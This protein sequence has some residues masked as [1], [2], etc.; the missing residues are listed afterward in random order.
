MSGKKFGYPVFV[1]IGDTNMEGNVYWV[2]YFAWL[3]K[4][5]EVFL[6]SIFPDF[7]KILASGY[8]IV[9]HETNIK[10]IASAFFTEE[11]ILEISM[12]EVRST[13]AK[14]FV[15]FQK[16]TGE[17]IAEGWQTLVFVDKQGDP[18]FIPAE[19]K[20]AVLKYVADEVK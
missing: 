11:I 4:A 8:N 20:E 5:R 3:G 13:S 17:K 2:N 10:H 14:M 19:L 6:I 15:K 16:K 7:L 18:A 1:S 12:G 9:T